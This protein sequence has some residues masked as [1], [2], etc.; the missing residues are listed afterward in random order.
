MPAPEQEV[1]ASRGFTNEECGLLAAAG[2]SSLDAILD[3]LGEDPIAGLDKLAT[4]AKLPNGRLLQGIVWELDHP[5]PGR[6]KPDQKRAGNPKGKRQ[7][8]EGVT[9][10]PS[11]RALDILGAVAFLALSLLAARAIIGRTGLPLGMREVVIANRHLDANTLIRPTDIRMAHS[12]R[13]PEISL[14]R[15]SVLGGRTRQHIRAGTVLTST[16]ILPAREVV[17]LTRT[18][19]RFERLRSTDLRRER[20]PCGPECINGKSLALVDH[21][22]LQNAQAGTP[23]TANLISGS[24]VTSESTRGLVL[25]PLALDERSSGVLPM[26]P[27]KVDLLLTSPHSVEARRLHDVL[28]VAVDHNSRGLTGYVLLPDTLPEILGLREQNR[29]L[30]LRKIR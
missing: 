12:M 20:L 5:R 22:L 29:A 19:G 28:I 17:V 25:L 15:Q 16:V 14:P 21:I 23:L 3:R 8:R 18:M 26:L 11:V 9:D 24:T 2:G 27:A 7:D 10:T 6:R 1:V 30:V 4:A 13:F